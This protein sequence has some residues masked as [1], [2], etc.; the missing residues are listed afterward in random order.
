MHSQL[1][2]FFWLGFIVCNAASAETLTILN[3]EEYLSE[4]VK[5]RWEAETGHT[6]N[7]IYFDSDEQRDAMLTSYD[8]DVID[9]AVIDE[10]ISRTYGANKLLVDLS[11]SEALPHTRHIGDFWKQRC[12]RYSSPYMYG[13]VGIAY[14]KDKIKTP[15]SS[16]W[17]YLQP[18]ENLR[19]HISLLKES[20]DILLPALIAR[21]YSNNTSD[22]E[23]LRQA[24]ED[25]EQLLPFILTFEYPI[26]YLG[27]N[28]SD[29]SLHMALVYS[30]DHE[31]MNEIQGAD[32]WGYVIPQEGTLV[33]TDCLSVLN[34][35]SK[36]DIA[37]HFI[38]FLNRPDIAAKNSESLHFATPNKAAR[39][40]QSREFSQNRSVYP[41]Q[42]ALNNML[43]YEVMDTESKKLRNRIIQSLLIKYEAQ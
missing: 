12:S 30:G 31:V 39:E 20:D 24:F 25:T 18:S 23:E 37:I 40:L 3:W 43:Y 2:L 28:P 15:P 34:T 21:G 42:N 35:S 6:I 1:S 9:I 41:E 8:D 19:G 13:T 33:W 27:N 7:Q 11:Q 4:D 5:S 38:N 14:R 10:S 17:D 22:R 36:K 16:W 29:D 26:T 32:H